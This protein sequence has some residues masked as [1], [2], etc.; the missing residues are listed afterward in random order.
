M[1]SS[2]FLSYL[3]CVVA[4]V[5]GLPSAARTV[6]A[7][8][9]AGADHAAAHHRQQGLRRVPEAPAAAGGRRGAGPRG[10]HRPARVVRELPGRVHQ[11]AAEPR[12]QR[13]RG[14]RG[15]LHASALLHTPRVSGVSESHQ[16]SSCLT[17]P[18]AGKVSL[19][20][21][22][23]KTMIETKPTGKTLYWI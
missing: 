19:K 3:S 15:R 5:T 12:R 4:C 1:K 20:Y 2:C 11:A 17:V 18:P 9:R 13:Q 10:H 22:W 23:K 21:G 7:V 14:V 16:A 8:L 6:V